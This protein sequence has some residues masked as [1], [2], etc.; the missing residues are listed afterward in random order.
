[1]KWSYEHYLIYLN[2]HIVKTGVVAGGA[3]IQGWLLIKFSSQQDRHFHVAN[4]WLGA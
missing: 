2:F 4:L 1:M 3:L